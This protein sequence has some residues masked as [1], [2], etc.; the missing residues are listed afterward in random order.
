MVELTPRARMLQGLKRKAKD[1]GC[2]IVDVPEG[3][4]LYRAMPAPQ[5]GVL[6]GKRATVGDMERLIAKAGEHTPA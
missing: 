6:I 2:F 3:Y 1:R 5:R 4:L